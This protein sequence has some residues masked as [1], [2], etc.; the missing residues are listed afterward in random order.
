MCVCLRAT[1]CLPTVVMGLPEVFLA[2]RAL[3]LCDLRGNYLFTL[4]LFKRQKNKTD[5][6]VPGLLQVTSILLEGRVLLRVHNRGAGQDDSLAFTGC[7]LSGS[8]RSV[9]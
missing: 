6:N 8:K 4:C 5:V 7:R 1:I 3:G 2:T 9:I